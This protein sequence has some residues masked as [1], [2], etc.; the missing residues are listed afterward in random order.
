MRSIIQRGIAR[1]DVRADVDI[2]L[3]TAMINGSFYFR[4]IIEHKGLD[5][6]AADYVAD[7]VSAA[8]APPTAASRRGSATATGGREK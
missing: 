8:V 5:H 1:G 3:L 6:R 2:E 7:L 4:S